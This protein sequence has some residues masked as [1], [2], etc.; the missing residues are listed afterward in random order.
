MIFDMIF[1]VIL[2]S[3]YVFLET[4]FKFY[5]MK[6]Q[7]SLD[8]ICIGILLAPDPDPNQLLGSASCKK[9]R[10]LSDPDLQH[11]FLVSIFIGNVFMT[12]VLKST[13]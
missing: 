10:I 11:C 6:N 3:I 5:S 4:K 9:V 12:S 13:S 8:K 7:V 1:Q 2:K